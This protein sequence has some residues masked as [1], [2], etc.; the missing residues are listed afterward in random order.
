M[1]CNYKVKMKD[2]QNKYKFKIFC[3][4]YEYDDTE[5]RN[6]ISQRALISEAGRYVELELNPNTYV[7]TAKL[8]DKN[9]NVISTSTPIDLPLESMIV[10]CN[11]DATTKS[12]IITLQ[13][14][15]TTSIPLGDLISGL[16][17][18]EELN[19]VRDNLE[20]VQNELNQYKTI[21][22]VIPKVEAEGEAFTLNDTGNAT[23]KMD[24]KGNTSQEGTPTPDSPQDIHVVSGDNEIKVC[25]KNLL[26]SED[27]TTKTISGV[28]F[29][30][31]SDG[32]ITANGTATAGFN[33]MINNYTWRTLPAGTYILS[34]GVD[35][36]NNN[37]YF[38]YLD[39]QNDDSLYLS[40]ISTNTRTYSTSFDFKTRIVVRSGVTLNNV[41]FKPMIEKGSTATSYEPYKS[42]TYPINLGSIELCKIGDYQ[43]RIYKDNGKWYLNKQIGKVVLDGSENW[44]ND[45]GTQGTNYRHNIYYASRM[46][47]PTAIGSNNTY[48]SNYFIA[49]NMGT[50]AVELGKFY[51]SGIW[52][53][54]P[55]KNKVYDLA[56]W[57]TWLSTHNTIVYY[58]LATPTTTE[59]TDTTLIEQLDN[60]EKAYSYD[61]QTNISQIN[62]DAPFIISASALYDLNNLVTRVAILET[63]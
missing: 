1:N 50:D 17:T 9:N 62:N 35:G 49:S 48:I 39:V 18:E 24:L 36:E 13:N 42:Q 31:N 26:N 15:N 51:M 63:E 16:A 7:L 5:L 30:K 44:N 46:T 58:V 61:T 29:T 57:K 8:K 47:I 37:T 41:V 4:G 23:L 28:T 54:F 59:I 25:G 38:T 27:G 45:S 2:I 34:D 43:D 33:Y 21:Y 53:V 60:L 11:Y 19:E 56:Q 14:G 22:N 40:T 55:D 52:L 12:L 20:V 6:E 10:D 32:T 3:A